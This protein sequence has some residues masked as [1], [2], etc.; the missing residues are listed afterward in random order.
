MTNAE[1]FLEIFGFDGSIVNKCTPYAHYTI[2]SCGYEKCQ[3]DSC[4]SRFFPR[5]P[6]WWSDNYKGDSILYYMVQVRYPYSDW[7]DAVDNNHGFKFCYL[8]LYD[9][10]LKYKEYKEKSKKSGHC[11]WKYRIVKRNVKT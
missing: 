4:A 10:I 9:A 2:G 5:C 11:D 7:V 1:K 8:S 3:T 6:M